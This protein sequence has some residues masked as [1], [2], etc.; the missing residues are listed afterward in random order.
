M[1]VII[2]GKFLENKPKNNSKET[3]L[4]SY[5]LYTDFGLTPLYNFGQKSANPLLKKGGVPHYE[6]SLL[7]PVGGTK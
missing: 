1:I 6:K 3:K 5:G 4:C 7:N 2:P